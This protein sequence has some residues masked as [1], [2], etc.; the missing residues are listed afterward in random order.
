VCSARSKLF[1]PDRM[2][3]FAFRFF[4]GSVVVACDN[5]KDIVVYY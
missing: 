3:E 5:G 1:L 2:W 4:I